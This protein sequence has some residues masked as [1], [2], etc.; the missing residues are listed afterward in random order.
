[1]LLL[2]AKGDARMSNLDFT[3]GELGLW[4]GTDTAD[5]TWNSPIVDAGSINI[6]LAE[7]IYDPIF[8]T[9]II[10]LGADLSITAKF[11]LSAGLYMNTGKIALDYNVTIDD[12]PS[13]TE[14]APYLNQ[15]IVTHTSGFSLG[16]TTF[17]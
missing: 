14:D 7:G 2:A 10:Q 5:L 6:P 4:N 1:M 11:G 3:S 16:S 9:A 13:S 12:A 15:T 8:G 17:S